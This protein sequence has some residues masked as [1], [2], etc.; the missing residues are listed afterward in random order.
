MT[1]Q[2][3]GARQ[4]Q[5]SAYPNIDFDM[6]TGYRASANEHHN[7]FELNRVLGTIR[8]RK[9]LIFL[10]VAAL[11]ALTAFVLFQI[12]PSYRAQAS[13]VVEGGRQNIADLDNVV[14]DIQ[15]DYFTVHTEAAIITSR[16]LVAK[17]LEKL[18]IDNNPDYQAL[19]GLS[20]DRLVEMQKHAL[21][22]A[23]EDPTKEAT[24]ISVKRDLL[25]NAF[26]SRLSARPAASSRV[27]NV[28]FESSDPEFAALAVNSAVTVYI[29]DQVSLKSEVTEY[30]GEWLSTRVD[31]LREKMQGAEVRLEEF[32]RES[33]MMDLKGNSIYQ[34]QLAQLNMELIRA[35]NSRA[36]AQAR[37]EQV[38]NLLNSSQG[39]ETAASVLASPLIQQLRQQEATVSRKIGELSTKYRPQHPQMKLA[40]A[41]RSDLE[42][43]IKDEVNK[44]VISLNNELE[45]ANM[46]ELNLEQDI[47]DLTH[48][49]E[50]EKESAVTLRALESDV[51]A[52]KDLYATILSRFKETDVQGG[53]GGY[54]ADS[55]IISYASVPTSPFKP[56]RPMIL[57]S[58][59]IMSMIIAVGISI[60]IE[61]SMTGYHSSSQ[62]EHDLETPVLA[63]LPQIDSGKNGM[64]PHTS[65]LHLSHNPLYSESMRN[66]RSSL[67]DNKRA[68]DP[69]VIMV[70]SSVP[71]EGKTSTVFSL[72]TISRLLNQKCLLIDCDLR[73]SRLASRLEIETSAGL[74]DYLSETAELREILYK[75][76]KTGV[77]FIPAGKSSQHP[78]DLLG[79]KRFERFIE[80]LR[81]R[82]DYIFIDAPPLMSV[83]DALTLTKHTDFTL[84]IVRWE[85]TPRSSVQHGIKML[86]EQTNQGIGIA[87][88][89][90]DVRKH[91]YYHYT[92]SD[93]IYFKNYSYSPSA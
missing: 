36:E 3:A 74:G 33:G 34:E 92:D 11:T 35:R 26:S 59:I 32:K 85:K 22:E 25:I 12:Q 90:V 24:P 76:N 37:V 17:V 55:R 38:R 9:Y 67:L 86:R 71:D 5:G 77:Y 88:S 30:A 87:L 57:M 64:M 53:G 41:E 28:T 75:D 63:M 82:F 84:Y 93:Y 69:Q 66:L 1:G 20:P 43:K 29:E 44:I 50:E 16:S 21:E 46:R 7:I 61:F 54:T 56:N 15:M 80:G 6:P 40:E 79:T 68:G 19:L 78:L 52:N 13:V 39:V 8:R 70:T 65:L 31:T 51:K 4:H 62:L 47:A 60:A 81:G 83:T 2:S 10:I 27:I 48:R 73:R 42:R 58:A 89:R 23:A 45:I 49:V 72:A 18:D 91:A 14:E